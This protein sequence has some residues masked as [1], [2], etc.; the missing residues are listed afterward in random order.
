MVADSVRAAG[1]ALRRPAMR[2]ALAAYLCFSVAEWAV[3]IALMV[4]AYGKAGV[5]GASLVSVAQMVPAV[6]V[7]P[8]AATIGDRMHRGRALAVGY[9]VQGVL[10]L[11]TAGALAADLSLPVVAVFGALVTAS[12]TL[13]RPVHNAVVPSL[14]ATPGELL[15][16]NAATSTLE[17]LGAF[18]GPLVS[19]GLL[20][21]GGA[22]SVF[23]TF[24]VLL[25]LVT[26]LVVRLPVPTGQ[27]GPRVDEPPEDGDAGDVAR[28][29]LA[30]VR[31]LGRDHAASVLVAMVAGQYVVV[32][33]M[34]V[35]LIVV[36]L[37]VLH[38]GSS[39]PGV[40][41]SAL[42]VGG[43]L[44]ALGSVLLVGRRRLT[45]ALAAGLLLTGLP[46][47]LLPFGLV[48][49]TAGLLLAV[50][51]S[52]KAFFDV[53]GRTLLQRAVPDAVLS[54]VF[55]VQ[56]SAM[57]AAIAIGA[58]LAPLAVTTLGRSGAL[59]ATGA[60]LPAT[61]LLAW[62]WLRRLDLN[63]VQPGPWLALLR[64]VPM[65]RTASPAVLESLSRSA[66]ELLVPAQTVV[67][68]EGE[69]GDQFFVIAEGEVVVT[70]GEKEVRRLGPGASFG[71][72]ALLHDV[73][74]TATVQAVGP[75]RLV[76]LRRDEFLRV[77]TSS[78]TARQAADDVARDYLTAD[79]SD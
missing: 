46:I 71:E 12:I 6:I 70:R 45:P 22:G 68:R 37:D 69:P 39:G 55:G 41:G 28:G 36:A 20:V 67:V 75:V 26:L 48:P 9:G 72:I 38:T 24:G 66:E 49:V 62:R 27:A 19:G 60:L 42:G 50:A 14:A 16:G 78:P 32:G 8:M 54:R 74:R 33:A 35:L 23:A 11:A 18:L 73:P 34:D 40:L 5:G 4:W 52:G 59:V 79:A 17:G 43:V 29:A 1:A 21:A 30:G 61:G 76:V 10:M 31:E 2:R 13:T 15:A 47:A 44:G 53:A 7:A 58:A 64:S 3:W 77:V 65:L 56:E 63:A 51:G 57:N 25:V